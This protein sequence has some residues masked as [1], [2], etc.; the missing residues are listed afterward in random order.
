MAQG[1]RFLVLGLGSFGTALAVRMATNGCRVTGVDSDEQRVEE[2]KDVIYEAVVADVTDRE[3]LAQLMVGQADAVFISLGESIEPSLLSALHCREL[4]AKR[5]FV[6]GVTAE[7]GKIL[8]KLGVERVIFPEAEMA[9]QLADSM[10]WP[11]VLDRLTI[12]SEYSLAE[13]A[14]PVCLSGKTLSQAE[15][16]RRFNLNVMGIKDHLTGK[17]TLNP[18]ADYLL[19]DDQLLLVIGTKEQIGQF[20]ELK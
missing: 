3:T 12:D 10:T 20:L 1:K 11:N 19:T 18:G 16:R 6:K 14:V 5:V 7:H 2:V 17:L 8:N 13:I 9:E 15:L 4:G